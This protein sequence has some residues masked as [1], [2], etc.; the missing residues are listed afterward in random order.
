MAG[1]KEAQRMMEMQFMQ[2]FNTGNLILDTLVKG[3]I[4]TITTAAFFY[5]KSLASNFQQFCD[6][7]LSFFGMT[8]GWNELMFFGTHKPTSYG[9][10][11]NF[12]VKLLAILHH[13]DK[14][15]A[16]NS[17]IR[18]LKEFVHEERDILRMEY[19]GGFKAKKTE[20]LIP[21]TTEVEKDVFCKVINYFEI[22]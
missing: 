3:L 12:S 7:I 21:E 8:N 17:S 19:E 2:S 16:N 13:L 1:L 20:Q 6:R 18:V 9:M 11:L 5:L 4:V 22:K 10:Q 15:R 14:N